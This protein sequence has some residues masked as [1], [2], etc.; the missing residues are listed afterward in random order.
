[1][2][3]TSFNYQSRKRNR[4]VSLLS[5]DVDLSRQVNSEQPSLFR[6]LSSPHNQDSRCFKHSKHYL[7]LILTLVKNI[8]G[9]FTESVLPGLVIDSHDSNPGDFQSGLAV[10]HSHN[11]KQIDL[12]HCFH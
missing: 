7:R 5:L 10:S 11:L 6:V 2:S 1:M 8:V 3:Y 12:Q 9:N 4:Q